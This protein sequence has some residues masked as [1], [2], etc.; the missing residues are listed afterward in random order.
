M[1]LP[2]GFLLCLSMLAVAPASAAGAGPGDGGAAHLFGYYPKPGRQADFD[3]GYRRHLQWHRDHRDPLPWYGWYVT[4]GA[5]AGMFV[6]G[7]FGAP[8]AAFDARV[9]PAGDA[10]DG[11][12][13]VTA[14]ADPAFRA[15]YR[16][17]REF[18]TGFPLERRRPTKAVQ[19]FHYRLKP[20]AGERFEA[21]LRAARAGLD[22]QAGAPAYTWYELVVG[23]DSPAYLLMV[24]RDGW[25]GYDVHP[26]GLEAV[27]A[28]S[29]RGE[30][31]L[32]ALTASVASVES[33]SWSYRADLSNVPPP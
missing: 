2:A 3:A 26:G 8:F 13:N 28:A 29:G 33:E 15:S 22:R 20:G 18:S 17:R 31:L 21:V 16:L 32:E 9:D 27:L 19:V 10:A 14:F 7:S 24:A 12:R 11:A 5:R 23:G 25:S 4:S 1:R 30:G 6:D